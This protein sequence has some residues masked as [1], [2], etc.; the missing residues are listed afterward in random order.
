M[1]G[2]GLGCLAL[3][4]MLVPLLAPGESQVNSGGGTLSAAAHVDFRIVIPQVLYLNTRGDGLAAPP[5]VFSNGRNIALGA[6]LR[7]MAGAG[8]GAS[9]AA[10]TLQARV[11]LSAAGRRGVSRS[12][13]CEAAAP[14]SQMSAPGL[15]VCTASMP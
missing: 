3:A 10:E 9:G 5:A 2:Y 7:G 13:A 14:P 12:T 8:A 4:A 1:K 11:I 15:L 6:T